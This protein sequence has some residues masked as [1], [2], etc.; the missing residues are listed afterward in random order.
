MKVNGYIYVPRITKS[1]PYTS[2][3]IVSFVFSYDVTDGIIT[4]GQDLSKS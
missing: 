1:T 2:E 4:S 3:I